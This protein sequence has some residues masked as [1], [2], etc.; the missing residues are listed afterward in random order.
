MLRTDLTVPQS[1]SCQRRQEAIRVV[2]C[3]APALATANV[4]GVAGCR[5][6]LIADGKTL[7]FLERTVDPDLDRPGARLAVPVFGKASLF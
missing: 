7:G 5:Q 2:L 3:I 1:S 4:M 6:S